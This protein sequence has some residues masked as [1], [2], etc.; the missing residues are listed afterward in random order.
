MYSNIRQDMGSYS[1]L[2]E[3]QKSDRCF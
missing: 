2:S 1:M 3:G